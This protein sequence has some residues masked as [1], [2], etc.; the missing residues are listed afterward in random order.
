VKINTS[1]KEFILR[2][3]AEWLMSQKKSESTTKTYVGVLSQFLEWSKTDINELE[4]HHI[5]AY[6]DHMDGSLKSTGTIEKHYVAISA[7]SKFLGKPQIVLNI[8]R[9]AKEKKVETPDTLGEWEEQALLMAIEAEGNPR[10][11]AIVYLLLHTGIRVSELCDMNRTDVK[12][13]EGR[14]FIQVRNSNG[15]VDRKVPLSKAASERLRNYIESLEGE[16]D[17]LFISSVNQRMTPRSVQYMLKKYHVHPHKLRHTFCQKLINKG[18]DLQT[19]SRLAGYKDLNMTK[20]YS[21]ELK[22]DLDLAI[23]TTFSTLKSS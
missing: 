22:Q 18:V 19:V 7:F 3:F 9:R 5:Q 2:S 21:R 10:N 14:E 6:L 13:E 23:D 15:E 12:V 17:A 4:S 20:R 16:I 11:I 8:D 1:T